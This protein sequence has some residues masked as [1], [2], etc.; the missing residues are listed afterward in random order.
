MKPQFDINFIDGPYLY[1][2]CGDD[3]ELRVDFIDQNTGIVICSDTIKIGESIKFDTLYFINLQ[4]KFY[5]DDHLVLKKKF[6]CRKKRVY[7]A[8]ESGALGDT[9]AW[10]PYLGN[11]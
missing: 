8:I 5:K 1:Y 11:R 4:F 2:R 7:I 3:A 10:I 9:L 6:N